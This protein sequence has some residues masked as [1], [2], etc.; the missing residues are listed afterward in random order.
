MKSVLKKR[1]DHFKVAILMFS[2]QLQA[3]PILSLC[4]VITFFNC[5]ILNFEYNCGT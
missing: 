1:C 4:T 3:L 2:G 5:S